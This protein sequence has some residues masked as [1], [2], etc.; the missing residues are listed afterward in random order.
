[1]A[2]RTTGFDRNDGTQR[3]AHSA[4]LPPDAGRRRNPVPQ[5]TPRHWDLL[6]LV[7]A[8]HTNAQIARRLGISEGTVGTHLENVYTRLNVSSRTAAVTCA[9]PDRV[10]Y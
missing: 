7:A 1:L 4:S 3:H 5:L 2:T 9:F 10:A 8:G 6:K